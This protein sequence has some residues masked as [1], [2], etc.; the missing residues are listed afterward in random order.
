MNNVNLKE[1]MTKQPM[2]V[3]SFSGETRRGK[4]SAN[5]E[6][7]KHVAVRAARRRARAARRAP[8]G[9]PS[10]GAPTPEVN[11]VWANEV[12]H[13]QEFACTNVSAIPM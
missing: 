12:L 7:H 11:E 1:Q 8:A 4:V 2:I 6:P 10:R 9:S 3:K 5:L 13:R